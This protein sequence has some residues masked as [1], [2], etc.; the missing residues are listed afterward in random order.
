M[1]HSIDEFEFEEFEVEESDG[2]GNTTRYP[3]RHT[4]VAKRHLQY[5]SQ[6]GRRT[7]DQHD[8]CNVYVAS[9][10]SSGTGLYALNDL[11]E[12]TVL[13]TE[14]FPV[15]QLPNDEKGKNAIFDEI[16][17]KLKGYP[18]PHMEVP[19]RHN[20]KCVIPLLDQKLLSDK[21]HNPS[22]SYLFNSSSKEPEPGN[23]KWQA[24]LKETK[25]EAGN[26][27]R[28]QTQHI[29]KKNNYIEYAFLDPGANRVL[30]LT[31]LTN[32]KIPA[33]T[34][35]MWN[36]P[37]TQKAFD[38]S[39]SKDYEMQYT[40]EEENETIYQIA[41]DL[42]NDG[43]STLSA[44]Q[45]LELNKKKGEEWIPADTGQSWNLRKGT[46]IAYTTHA[47]AAE[48][49]LAEPTA[50]AKAAARGGGPAHFNDNPLA[51]EEATG[52][53]AAKRHKGKEP[54]TIDQ[55][56]A[57]LP[58]PAESADK[59][60]QLEYV[61]RGWETLESISQNQGVDLKTLVKL[62]KH[63]LPKL[64]QNSKLAPNTRVI[65]S[66]KAYVCEHCNHFDSESKAEVEAHEKECPI[67]VAPKQPAK[68]AASG[69]GGAKRPAASHSA[70]QQAKRSTPTQPNK[71]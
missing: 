11:E 35:L 13:F 12:D 71:D 46:K 43:K 25:D 7:V 44:A 60:M 42:Q 16:E 70:K 17:R 40:T 58:T 1:S 54:G 48:I 30:Q 67:V 29:G 55:A 8:D 34:H 21:K 64:R 19:F 18:E 4:E 20:Y 53:R 15:K 45:L 38:S 26:E 39:L 2:A 63:W 28:Y 61:T 24:F 23:L 56:L 49:A 37:Y 27:T 52:G 68:A 62:N 10:E 65:L 6:N 57:D 50:S 9:D 47:S 66:L 51:S 69:G 14:C 41:L 3:S 33:N 5:V 36:Y 22:N 31:W 32:K 59:R